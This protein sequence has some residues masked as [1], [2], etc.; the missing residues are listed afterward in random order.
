MGEN[1][2]QTETMTEDKGLQ[3]ALLT[4]RVLLCVCDARAGRKVYVLI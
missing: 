4:L 1:E 3:T 2:R